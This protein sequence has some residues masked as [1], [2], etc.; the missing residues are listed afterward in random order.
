M[1]VLPLRI[2][3]SAAAA[4]APSSGGQSTCPP[5]LRAP[6]DDGAGAAASLNCF[7]QPTCEACVATKPATSLCGWCSEFS[8]CVHHYHVNCPPS[9]GAV[10]NASG[11]AAATPLPPS[12]RAATVGA[13]AGVTTRA[14]P[15]GYV[16]CTDSHGAARCAPCASQCYEF[17][18]PTSP[19][20]SR[21]ADLMQRLTYSEKI[22]LLNNDA[23]G[24]PRLN[25][26]PYT[27]SECL[28]GYATQASANGSAIISTQ[29]PIPRESGQQRSAPA[30]GSDAATVAA[31]HSQPRGIFQRDTGGGD[32]QGHRDGG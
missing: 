26:Q 20:E 17:L 1:L 31:A 32:W 13:G 12:P 27:T 15:A 4:A 16:T 3:V 6:Y 19:R 9:P 25:I 10:T 8:A 2:L 24:I 14:C 23:P 11:C 21:L 22:S 30:A 29:F 7:V 5:F 18:D 28:H